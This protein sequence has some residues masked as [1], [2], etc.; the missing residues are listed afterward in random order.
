M[1]ERLAGAA[2]VGAGSGCG[3]GAPAAR[4]V[5]ATSTGAGGWTAGDGAYAGCATGY[6][7]DCGW[8][9][10]AAGHAGAGPHEVVAQPVGC[11]DG[12]CAWNAPVGPSV[13]AGDATGTPAADAQASLVGGAG[14]PATGG[15]AAGT[16][17]SA[18]GRAHTLVVVALGSGVP[19]DARCTPFGEAV[20]MGFS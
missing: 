20:V 12:A 7:G 6:M 8:G 9:Y 14:Q 1:L 13:D 2:T 16:W 4:G 18:P 19:S 10:G 17:A 11:A 15:W 3:T 5:A